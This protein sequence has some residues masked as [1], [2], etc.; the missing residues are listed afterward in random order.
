MSEMVY[1]KT[2][3]T[4]YS[5]RT[6]GKTKSQ[7]KICPGPWNNWLM[8]ETRLKGDLQRPQDPESRTN[9]ATLLAVTPS[10]SDGSLVT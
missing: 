6:M 5:W 7:K 4:L 1:V 3:E 9:C 8:K 2:D 10:A